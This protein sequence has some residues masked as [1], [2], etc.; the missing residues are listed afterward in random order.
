MILKLSFVY[1]VT[2]LMDDSLQKDVF[3][4]ALVKF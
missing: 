1:F 2:V 4:K 3:R